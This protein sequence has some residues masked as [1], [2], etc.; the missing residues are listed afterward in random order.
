MNRGS[1]N[2]LEMDLDHRLPWKLCLTLFELDLM[3]D[4]LLNLATLHEYFHRLCIRICLELISQASDQYH[5]THYH[6]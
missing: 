6:I 4:F 5:T 3:W 2:K 1:I